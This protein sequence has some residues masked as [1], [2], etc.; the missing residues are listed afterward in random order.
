[1]P[2]QGHGPSRVACVPNA[3]GTVDYFNELGYGNVD[4]RHYLGQVLT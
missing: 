1:M 2:A 3:D 4:S